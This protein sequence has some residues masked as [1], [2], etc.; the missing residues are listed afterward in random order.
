MV[1]QAL[2][3]EQYPL[4]TPDEM[5]STLAGGKVLSK[6]DLS[7]AYLQLAVYEASWPNLTIN[8]HQGVNSFW[9]S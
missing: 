7:Q 3:V 8:T 5:F 9:C 1:N 4:L 2:A 6:L